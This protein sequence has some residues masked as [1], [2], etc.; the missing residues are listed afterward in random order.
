MSLFFKSITGNGCEL[1]FLKCFIGSIGLTLLW[2]PY[3]Y[4]VII[5]L[6]VSTGVGALIGYALER[7]KKNNIEPLKKE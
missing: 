1:G 6:I 2:L 7:K 4:M 5:I 3:T